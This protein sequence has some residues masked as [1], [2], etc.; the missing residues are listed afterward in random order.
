M[1]KIWPFSFYFLFFGAFASLVPF[2]VIFYQGLGFSG[3]QI[4]LLTGVA[5]LITLVAAPLG[6]GLAD[7]TRRHKLIMGLGLFMAIVLGVVL[8]ALRSFAAV[9]VLIALYNIFMAPVGS[10]ADSA[11]MTMLGDEKSMYGRVRLGGTFG[12]GIFAPI[13]GVLVQHYGLGIGFW[14]FTA[15]MVIN[16]MVSQK[17][18]YGQSQPEQ[19]SNNGGIWLLLQDKKWIFFLAAA[20]LSG[21][22]T[23]SVASYLYPYMAEMG[24][25]ETQ[26]GITSLLGTLTELPIFFFGHYLIKRFKARSLFITA[27]ALFGIRSL[28]FAAV[29]APAMMYVIQGAS[30]IIYPMMWIA[31]V[32]Y[33]DENAPEGL[34]STAQGIFNAVSFG[35][36]SAVSGFIGG[37]LL[38]SIG[39]RAMFFVFGVGIL[40]LLAVI[41]VARRFVIA[42]AVLQ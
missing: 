8:P 42:R 22:G 32:S 39:G 40:V 26:M 21:V 2:F 5:P 27:I 31:G 14:M 3:T 15:I 1:K 18:D 25:T 24:A 12:W 16:L 17:F 6:T 29:D 33:A 7:A 13:A 41:E 34:K 20:F 10:L 30:G 35:I 36:G 28:L 23:F 4:G 19:A 11:T 37:I 38:E 9:C